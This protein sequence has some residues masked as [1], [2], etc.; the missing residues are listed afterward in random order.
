MQGLQCQL[1]DEGKLQSEV[2]FTNEFI[3]FNSIG[4]SPRPSNSS[5]KGNS[6]GNK[7]RLAELDPSNMFITSAPSDSFVLCNL[8]STQNK[9]SSLICYVLSCTWKSEIQMWD[10]EK[11][12]IELLSEDPLHWLNVGISV[13]FT[14]SEMPHIPICLDSGPASVQIWVRLTG[15]LSHPLNSSILC[16]VIRQPGLPKAR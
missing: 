4:R 3:K 14:I 11:V 15:Q 9:M 8:S 2:K 16:I 1:G 13:V 6:S 10:V 5:R 12:I 7:T